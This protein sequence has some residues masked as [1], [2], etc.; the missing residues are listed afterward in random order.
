VSIPAKYNTA[1]TLGQEISSDAV[2]SVNVTY[3]LKK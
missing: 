1:T 3:A 2:G